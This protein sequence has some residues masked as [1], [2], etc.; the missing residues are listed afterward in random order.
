MLSFS[1]LSLQPPKLVSKFTSTVNLVRI[2]ILRRGGAPCSSIRKLTARPLK[3]WD[4]RL[5]LSPLVHSQKSTEAHSS[6]WSF[7]Y[8]RVHPHPQCF[9]A[10]SSRLIFL[11]FVLSDLC[12]PTILSRSTTTW[13]LRS[14]SIN[15]SRLLCMAHYRATRNNATRYSIP[16]LY[17][18]HWISSYFWPFRARKSPSFGVTYLNVDPVFSASLFHFTTYISLQSYI[19]TCTIQY[20]HYWRPSLSPWG[21][22]ITSCLVSSWL[23]S[24]NFMISYR[25]YLP[26]LF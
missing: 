6:V 18:L 23:L 9:P 10:S 3:S 26:D 25:F 1:F 2:T 19:M 14:G 11:F 15:P 4:S 24:T 8:L 13:R 20:V 7:I 16:S 22:F 5:S 12:T 21:C 17:Y